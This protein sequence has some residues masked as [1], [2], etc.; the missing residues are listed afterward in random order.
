MAVA[1]VFNEQTHVEPDGSLFGVPT[2][3][4]RK[5]T[6]GSTVFQVLLR[7]F[8]LGWRFEEAPK[9]PS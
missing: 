8:G 4:F 5:V 7:W 9:G 2:Q 6:A 1:K 3:V